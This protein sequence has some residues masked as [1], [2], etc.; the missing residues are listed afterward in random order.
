MASNFSGYFTFQ[1][2]PSKTYFNFD[3]WIDNIQLSSNQHV[4]KFSA[5]LAF[6]HLKQ[7]WRSKIF[8]QN[9]WIFPRNQNQFWGQE[10]RRWQE[11]HWQRHW[12]RRRRR[13]SARSRTQKMTL[14]IV[15][16]IL[17]CKKST[18]ACTVRGR[19]HWRRHRRRRRCCR[20][21]TGSLAECKKSSSPQQRRKK[22]GKQV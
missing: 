6:C 15:W 20:Q 1:I 19:H 5:D 8:A 22:S 9:N 21:A 12:R 16:A 17:P 3:H 13:R 14:I 4:L 10:H 2:S 11:Q 18:V 7:F